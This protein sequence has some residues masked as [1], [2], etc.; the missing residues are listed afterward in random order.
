MIKPE[1]IIDSNKPM[2]ALTFDDGPGKYT[3]QLLDLLEKHDA[4][5]TFFM[6]GICIEEYTD[7]VRKMK[8]MGCDIGNHTTN[9]A[10]LT[11]LDEV[12]IVGELHTTD[13]ILQNVIGQEAMYMRPP[14]GSVNELVQANTDVP[15]I[16]WSVDTRD[17]EM[18]DATSVKDYVLNNVQ[19]GDIV[20][21]HDIHETTIQS[22]VELIPELIER[23]YQ[24]VTVSEMAQVRGA[25]L[26]NGVIYRDFYKD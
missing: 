14:Y 12:G 25:R 10:R 20:L 1:R 7:E 19:D 18:K 17:W 8:E 2:I 9:H 22:M 5:A 23:G 4:R 6:V 21:L 24:L 11:N 15:I 3:M 16:M 13:R 26:Q